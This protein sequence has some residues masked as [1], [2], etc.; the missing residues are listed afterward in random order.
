MKY[1]DIY[2]VL[3]NQ[4]D[5]NERIINISKLELKITN[6]DFESFSHTILPG[7]KNFFCNEHNKSFKSTNS[8]KSDVDAPHLNEIANKPDAEIEENIKFRYS[9][10]SHIPV[11]KDKNTKKKKHKKE[12][13]D[14]PKGVIFL[15]HG[16]NEKD[17]NKYLPWAYKLMELT[18]K[19]IILFPIAFHMNRTPTL[20]LNPKFMKKVNEERKGFFPKMTNASFANSALSSRLQFYP[21][22]FL[23]SG[24]QSFF[25]ILQLVRE[26]RSGTHPIIE[27]DVPIDFFA[28]SI[29]SFLANI[30]LMTNSYNYLKDSKLFHFCGGPTLNRMSAASKYILD[31]EANIAVYSYFI[32]HLEQEQKKDER[33]KHYFSKLHPEGMFFKCMLNIH[34]MQNFRDKRFNE[35]SK[36]ISALAL[37]QDTVVP[38]QEVKNTLQ[39][40]ERKIPIK[41]RVFDFDYKYDHV[42]PFPYLE[43]ISEQVDKQFNRVFKAAAKHLK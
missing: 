5:L 15:L 30:L 39:G 4:F 29:G 7:N 25:D 33:L 20:W 9:V 37:K 17:W 26:I 41:V 1:A 21:Q 40:A 10:F 38:P 6:L 42:T 8:F 2:K 24:L 14:K 11:Q 22:R 23:W 32:E 31:S 34:K 19:H 35:L 43:K 16:L 12:K 28:Y 3:K 13:K 27:K 18:G 36:Q